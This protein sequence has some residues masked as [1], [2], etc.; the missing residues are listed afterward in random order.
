MSDLKILTENI[1]EQALKQINELVNH[2]AFKEC[3]I[4][5]MPDVHAGKGCVIGF[6]ADMK[7]KVV[8]NL[9]G[10]DIGCG[11]YVAEIG[12]ID[13][14][15]EKLDDVIRIHVPSGRNVHDAENNYAKHLISSLHC[16]GELKEKSWL[17]RSL[18]TLGGGNHFVE[19]D[20]SDDMKY[21]VIH[22]GSRNLGKQVCEIYQQK[23]IDNISGKNKLKDEIKET[24]RRYTLTG[25]QKEIEKRIQELKEAQK[26]TSP[27][28]PKELCYLDGLD[29]KNYFHDMDVCQRFASMNRVYM[30]KAIC[31]N[32]GWTTIRGVFESI[33]NY[34]NFSDRITRKGAISAHKGER[35]II[36]LNMRDGCIIG[37]GKGNPDWNCSAPHGAGRI[38]SRSKAK[39]LV[40]M[41]EF[42]KSMD[43]IYTT[44]VNETTID[45][46]PMAY[47]KAQEIIDSIKP[48][49]EIEKIIKPV[50]N[51]KASE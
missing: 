39:E 9:I 30:A 48:T 28:I 15:Y 32:M 10:V 49:V 16:A 43:G 6:T 17:Y 35:L 33:H 5:I 13:I 4:R 29:R 36:P 8:P 21:L 44:S 37:V 45:E 19:I 42:K 2:P 50:Y 22:S 47:K 7:D 27:E 1:E 18:G 23:A 12:E 41:D 34:I 31:E 14:D 38:M 3:K 26:I 25:K 11:I 24:I 46:S 51:F 40:S 20:E